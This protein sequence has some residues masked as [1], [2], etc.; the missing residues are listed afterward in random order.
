M[1]ENDEFYKIKNSFAKNEN[2]SIIRFVCKTFKFSIFQIF[3]Q[4]VYNW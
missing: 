4:F 2:K 1:I 3:D